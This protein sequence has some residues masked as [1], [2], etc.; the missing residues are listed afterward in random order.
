MGLVGV[1]HSCLALAG[2]ETSGSRVERRRNCVVQYG[3]FG[4]IEIRE[5]QYGLWDVP[6]S[7]VP[8]PSAILTA[9]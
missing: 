2:L 8:V 9:L 4:L 1:H 5:S 3:R 7:A 6:W